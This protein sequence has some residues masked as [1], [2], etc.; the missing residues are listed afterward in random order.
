MI[1]TL[2]ILTWFLLF[3]AVTSNHNIYDDD[4][5]SYH[6][7]AVLRRGKFAFISQSIIVFALLPFIVVFRC[8]CYTH[9]HCAKFCAKSSAKIENE[10]RYVILY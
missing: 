3:D 6:P 9:L 5:M 2:Q 7:Y 10:F 4:S 1:F 8:Y